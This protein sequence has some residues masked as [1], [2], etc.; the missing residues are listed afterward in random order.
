MIIF[1]SLIKSKRPR[2]GKETQNDNFGVG[3]RFAKETTS[4]AETESEGGQ[5]G[6]GPLEGPLETDDTSTRQAT[7]GM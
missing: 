5:A 6:Q 2:K 3:L 4:G 7:A 1:R